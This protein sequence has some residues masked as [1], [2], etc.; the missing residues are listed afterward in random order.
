MEFHGVV[1]GPLT[2]TW[3]VPFLFR[4]C[5]ADETVT[6]PRSIPSIDENIGRIRLSTASR[7]LEH[8]KDYRIYLHP[9]RTRKMNMFVMTIVPP[10]G[11]SA[12]NDAVIPMK[13]ERIERTTER[14]NVERK[15]RA[16]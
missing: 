3:S 10:A 1:F 11:R 14:S 2:D 15:P 5:R 13:T 9:E 4:P 12:K 7:Q 6:S 8:P 16:T